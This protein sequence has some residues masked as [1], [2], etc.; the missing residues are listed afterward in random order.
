LTISSISSPD[1]LRRRSPGRECLIADHLLATREEWRPR[2]FSIHSAAFGRRGCITH[3]WWRWCP[4]RCHGSA[5]RSKEGR[6][7]Q[8]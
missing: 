5:W 8:L 1:G 2:I 7:S 6:P 4:W 3:G